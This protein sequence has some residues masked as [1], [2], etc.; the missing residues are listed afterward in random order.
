MDVNWKRFLLIFAG[1]SAVFFAIN[2]FWPYE[3]KK[4]VPAK[5]VTPQGISDAL[6]A[7]ASAL[8]AGEGQSALNSLN[9]MLT[10]QYGVRVY[11]DGTTG[12]LVATDTNG[13]KVGQL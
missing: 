2:Y 9:K 8:E 12:K 6:E 1:G 11:E 13:V 4:N 3:P 5:A 10:E 7:Y